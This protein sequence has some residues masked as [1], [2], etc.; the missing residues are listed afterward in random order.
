MKT[1][2]FRGHLWL[3]SLT[4]F[5]VTTSCIETPDFSVIPALKFE[6]IEVLRN[7]QGIES[8]VKVT[9]SFTD[10]DG[11]LGYPTDQIGD[12]DIFLTKFRK[13]KG[14]FI[15]MKID[16]GSFPDTNSIAEPYEFRL[17]EGI[18]K[19]GV[20]RQVEGFIDVFDIFANDT[21]LSVNDTILFEVE[22]QDLAKH[23][24]N[25][26]RTSEVVIHK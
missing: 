15:E 13:V 21:R 1:F 24:S 18:S 5:I 3:L 23:I 19:P 12:A 17:P 20:K 22:I 11:D 6:K 9:L 14:N 8:V 26:V 16:T 4:I 10:G 2:Y 25:R 7:N